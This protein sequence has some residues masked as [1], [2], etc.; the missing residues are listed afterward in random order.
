MT[1]NASDKEDKLNVLYDQME[2]QLQ[3]VGS[4]AIE[5]LLQD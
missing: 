2:T 5:D 3:Y 4:S 1:S